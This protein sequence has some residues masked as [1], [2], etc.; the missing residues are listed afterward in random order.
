MSSTRLSNEQLTFFN[1]F[2]YL[3]FPGLLQDCADEIIAGFERVWA[4]HGGGHAG[5]THDGK[6]RSAL[7]PFPGR[8][9]FLA[10]LL[11]DPR[12]HD[13]AASILG[14]DFNYTGGDGNLYVGDTQWHSDGYDGKR[15]PSIKIAFYLDPM[16]RDT[17]ALRVIPGS[18]HVGDT[19]ADAVQSQI[20]VN[21][22]TPS[23]EISWGLRPDQVPA[24][25]L[26]TVPGDVVVFNH[27]LKH[28]AFGGS[29][30]RRMFTMNFCER[31]PEDRVQ[32]FAE[33]I[34]HEA[35]FWTDTL[36]GPYMIEGASPERM[37]HLEQGLTHRGRLQERYAE[38]IA[39]MAEPARG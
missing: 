38:L 21:G 8:D 29:Q 35:R 2:G 25:V 23:S 5:Q 33:K 12:I 24:V 7:F 27:N 17:G 34:S 1:T 28:A 37:V 3:A 30:R 9:P 11:D 4:S 16:T 26:E 20:R 39:T 15:L 31:Y 32:E 10:S 18:H 36:F 6:Q 13:I 19:Y 22:Q 14:D